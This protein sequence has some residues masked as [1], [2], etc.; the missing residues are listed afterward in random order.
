[1]LRKQVERILGPNHPP[2][3]R[4]YLSG[5]I[6]EDFSFRDKSTLTLEYWAKIDPRLLRRRF[7]FPTHANDSLF[8][9]EHGSH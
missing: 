4:T 5:I 8:H 6:I 7:G 1:M 3:L 9:Y 2:P